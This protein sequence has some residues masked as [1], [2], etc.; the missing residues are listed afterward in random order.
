MNTKGLDL[1][2]IDETPPLLDL[3]LVV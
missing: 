1:V 2:E 3:T